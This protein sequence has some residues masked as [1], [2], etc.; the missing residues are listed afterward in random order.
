MVALS[1]GGA[2]PEPCPRPP[3]PLGMFKL[4]GLSPGA[5]SWNK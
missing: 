2:L 5:V 4:I 1:P 3:A